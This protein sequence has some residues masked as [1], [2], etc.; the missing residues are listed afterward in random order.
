MQIAKP[1]ASP[2]SLTIKISA[3]LI[4]AAL[5]TTPSRM[6]SQTDDCSQVTNPVSTCA[7]GCAGTA[8][9]QQPMNGLYFDQYYPPMDPDSLLP[10]EFSCTQGG[11]CSVNGSTCGN[12]GCSATTVQFVGTCNGVRKTTIHNSCCE[13]AT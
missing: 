5:T 2:S 4:T 12:G 1:N 11:S 10:L 3:L 6:N 7:Y 13:L 8:P 9:C